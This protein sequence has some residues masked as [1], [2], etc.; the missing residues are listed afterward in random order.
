MRRFVAGSNFSRIRYSYT[1]RLAS[2]QCTTP[3]C[4]TPVGFLPTRAVKP[5]L[6]FDFTT[7]FC[8]NF[9]YPI[10]T[11]ISIDPNSKSSLSLSRT[12]SENTKFEYTKQSP[13]LVTMRVMEANLLA[14]Q[15][16]SSRIHSYSP[17]EQ[18]YNNIKC[19][20]VPSILPSL[21]LALF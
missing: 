5:I 18:K 8:F 1:T 10:Y 4:F 7:S 12:Q 20:I 2:K 21:P 9:R 19:T 17:A 11:R 15:V 6:N 14:R 16:S 3:L 13:L